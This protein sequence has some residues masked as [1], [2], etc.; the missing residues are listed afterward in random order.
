MRSSGSLRL[1][2]IAGITVKVHWS[3]A[4]IAM[5]LAVSLVQTIGVFAG[6]VGVAAFLASILAHEFAHALTARRYG[7]GTESIQLWA[8]G[9][10]ARLDR[11]APSARA[12]GWIA[13]AGPIA[14]V[15]IGAASLGGWF[16]LGGP[17]TTS[18]LVGMLGWLGLINALLAVFNLLP[19]SPLD[20]GRIVKAVRWAI[21]GDRHRAA[22][23]A[24]R[25][26]VFLG[27]SVAALGFFL[28]LNDQSGIWLIITGAFIAV[29]A[30]VE[31]NAATIAGRLAGLSVR[32]LTWFGVA[33]AGHDMD[34][35]SMLWQR[36]RLGSAG[37]VAVTDDA[38]RVEG[39][40]LEDDLWALPADDRPWVMLTQL[41]VPFERTAQAAPDDDLATVLPKLNL[42]KPVVTVWEDG[43]LVG[44]VP[45][46][47]LRERLTAAGL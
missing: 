14:S 20:G 9:G 30:H 5:L 19:G 10:V 42:A 24:G 7:V 34:A 22:R 47:R 18:D 45:P 2:S 13:A 11:E 3:V 33:Q 32:D 1:G 43:R 15:L 35:D 27:W 23:E 31:I 4:L 25:A 41:M 36:G 38:G 21:H 6:L 28:I 16:L 37:A 17:G 39:L 29:N 44:L 26:G 46:R 40:V 8:L 12:E